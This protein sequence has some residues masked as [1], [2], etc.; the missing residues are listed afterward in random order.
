[1]L[2]HNYVNDYVL[3]KYRNYDGIMHIYEIT[4]N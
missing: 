3:Y 2:L 1:M 4:Y